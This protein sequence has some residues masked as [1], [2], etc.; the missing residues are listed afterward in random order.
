[1][2]SNPK[3]LGQ[4]APAAAT[5]VTLYIC[6]TTGA[7]SSSLVMCNTGAVTAAV[8]VSAVSDNSPDA[9][10][11]AIYRQLPV[12]AGDTF[13]STIGM[14]LATGGRITVSS[15]TASVAF[16]LFGAEVS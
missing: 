10:S 13:I 4:S 2:P 8:N 1:M 3:I 6:P 9:P 5:L 14:A 15:S 11:Q 7:V 16:T 12:A